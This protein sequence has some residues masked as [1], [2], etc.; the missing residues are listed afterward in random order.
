MRLMFKAL[1]ERRLKAGFER[2]LANLARLCEGAAAPS[3]AAQ[4]AA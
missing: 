4:R 3:A 2:S 1:L